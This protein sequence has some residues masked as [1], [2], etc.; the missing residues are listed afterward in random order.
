MLRAEAPPK[1]PPKAPAEAASAS[2]EAFG[3]RS[4]GVG[5]GKQTILEVCALGSWSKKTA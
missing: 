1:A 2:A 4:F 5:G 3:S